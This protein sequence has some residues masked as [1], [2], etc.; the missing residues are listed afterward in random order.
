M[1]NSTS[2]AGSSKK[3]KYLGDKGMVALIALLSAFV[4][5]ST[6]MYLPAL[7]SMAEYFNTSSNMINLTLILFFVFYAIATLFW[8]PLSDKYKRRPILLTGLILYCLGS[9]FC[10]CASDVNHLILSR[11]LQAI[12]G[13]AATAV[14]TAMV[15]DIYEGRKRE[16]ILALVQSMVIIAPIVAPVLGGL[17]LRITSW[18]GVFFVLAIIALLSLLGA[19]FMEETLEKR[20]DGTVLQTM[21]RLGVVLKNPGFTSLL[22]IFSLAPIP[23]MAYIASSS[24]IYVDGFGLSEQIYSYYFAGNALFSVIGPILYMRLSSHFE[25]RLIINICFAVIAMSGLLMYGL[26]ELKPWLFAISALPC[27]IAAG[28]L[29]PPSTNLMLEQQTKDTGS[30]SSLIGCFGIFGGSV[31]MILISLDWSNVIAALGLL[32][33]LTGLV[34]GGLWLIISSKSFVK[35]IPDSAQPDFLS[36][37]NIRKAKV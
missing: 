8:G 36:Q 20:Y 10:A 28:A 1:Q 15:K 18:R 14:A 12:G 31:G 33:L 7:P 25:R 23:M 32:Q 4:P 37:D 24:Y 13:G 27:A 21:G 6:D 5:L 22:V 17:M 26:G 9:V 3:Q 16:S 19:L 35:Q 11:V 2:A 29:R 34:C 30:A